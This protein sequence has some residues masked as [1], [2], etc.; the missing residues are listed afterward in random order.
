MDAIRFE[1][2]SKSYDLKT[3]GHGSFRDLV[4]SWFDRRPANGRQPFRALQDV[5]FALRPGG[6]LGI[7][8]PNGAG[9]STILKLLAKVSLPTEGRIEVNGRMAALIELGAGLHPELTGQENIWLYSAILGMTRRE[10]RQQWDAIVNFSEL[11][12]FIKVPLKK[13]S[14]GMLARLAFSIA[15]H[16]SANILLVDEVLAVGDVGFQ[17]KCIRRMKERLQQ[18]TT[19]V[20]VS[21]DISAVR[22]LCEHT[23]F[24]NKGGVEI[25]GK[26]EAVLDR[27][28]SVLSKTLVQQNGAPKKAELVSVEM[29]DAQG[30]PCLT[31][32]SGDRATF[33]AQF[34]FNE[35]VESPLFGFFVQRSDWLFVLATA[36]DKMGA[37][38]RSYRKGSR[39]SV[40]VDFAVNLLK[41][42]FH[43]GT[44][45]TDHSLTTYY[46][47]RFDAVTISVFENY[48][49]GGVADLQPTCQV[50]V[51]VPALVAAG[52]EP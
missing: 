29:L 12:Q 18:G 32:R 14:S 27:Y 47:I 49:H 45:V 43:I 17:N 22:E 2:V 9:K 39:V 37:E 42:L 52:R 7:V 25:Q 6:T 8:G 5:S 46:D 38:S 40:R 41:G 31:F 4:K 1:H 20:F 34:Q 11:G 26:T 19:I 30:R 23:I 33:H 35:D 24:L 51:E 50:E 44:Q 28:F 36:S 16:S 13:Y 48:S 3:L 21:H 15:A 10:I